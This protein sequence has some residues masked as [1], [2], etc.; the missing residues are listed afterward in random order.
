M[1]CLWLQFCVDLKDGVVQNNQPI[2]IWQCTSWV[3]PNQIW[4]LQS[5]GGGAYRIASALSQNKCI[6]IRG[7][8]PY[9]GD[10]IVLYDCYYAE[11][12]VVS[13]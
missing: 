10:S 5:I 11:A 8:S 3:N 9:Q 2:Q 12:W 13:T 1:G 4:S 7:N 6:D